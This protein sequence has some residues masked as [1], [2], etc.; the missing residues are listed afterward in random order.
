MNG[1][2]ITYTYYKGIVQ[3]N[4]IRSTDGAVIPCVLDNRDYQAFLQWVDAG[5][6][7]PEGWTGPTA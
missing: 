4:I 5:N 7:P 1:T 3:P 6:A 2:T